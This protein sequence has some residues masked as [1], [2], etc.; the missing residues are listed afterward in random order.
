MKNIWFY[1]YNGLVYP[2]LYGAAKA[3]S[4]LD[5]KI[6]EGMKGRKDL[7]G[8]LERNLSGFDPARSRIWFHVSSMGEFEQ[9]KPIIIQLKEEFPDSVTVVTFFSPSGYNHSRAFRFADV[10]SY[11]PFDSRASMIRFVRTLAPRAAVFI[12]YDIWPNA[13]WALAE[14]RIPVFLADATLSA[15]SKRFSPPLRSFHRRLF[16]LFE[17]IMTVS[18]SDA[19]QFRKFDLSFPKIEAAGDTRYD[20]VLQKS[21]AAQEIHLLP[22]GFTRRKKV[23]VV[24]SSWQTDEEHLIPALLRI[25]REEKSLLTIL[26]PH[27]PTEE[28][29]DQ[30]ENRLGSGISSIRFSYLNNYNGER[31]VIVDSIGILLTLYKYADVAYIGGGFKTGVH[32]VLEAAVYGIPVI[33]GPRHTRSQ[34]AIELL[35][36]GAGF[37]IRDA[38]DLYHTLRDLFA[39][40]KK[41]KA[42]GKTARELVQ[43]NTGATGRIVRHLSVYI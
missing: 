10:V 42:A 24:G 12:R 39:D 25:S 3:G 32:N 16:N 13:V 26:V 43:E 1:I 33:F 38:E 4:V 21:L 15:S 34:E 17:R 14:S 28:N 36:R 27:E 29:L 22:E 2:A 8:A 11:L 18:E 9:A 6:R 19:E 23:L 37:T 5:R 30:I 35:K 20:Q 41:R 40:S 7:F 31:V